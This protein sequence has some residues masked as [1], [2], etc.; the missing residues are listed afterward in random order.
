MTS[1]NKED[2]WGQG[3]RVCNLSLCFASAAAAK[4][5]PVLKPGRALQTGSAGGSQAAVLG[6]G[7][8]GPQTWEEGCKPVL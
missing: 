7:P 8:L 6:P 5:Q 1:P 4:E 3:E 2:L